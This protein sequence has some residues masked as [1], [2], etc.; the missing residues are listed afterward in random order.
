MA[1]LMARIIALLAGGQEAPE[2]E[3][4]TAKTPKTPGLE[5]QES[6]GFLALAVLASCGLLSFNA[7]S[8]AS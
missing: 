8:A 4:L 1:W 3:N 7:F 5:Q 2:K 6:R